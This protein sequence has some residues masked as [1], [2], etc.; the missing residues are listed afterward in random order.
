MKLGRV[1]LVGLLVLGMVAGVSAAL[2]DTGKGLSTSFQGDLDVLFRDSNGNLKYVDDSGNAVDTG[3][4]AFDV[5][6]VGD[7]DGDGDL[8]VLFRDPNNN[9]KYVDDS[10][11]LVDTG[12]QTN[13]V[14]GVADFDGDGDLDVLFQNKF[15]NLVYADDSGNRVDTNADTITV[16]GVGDFDGDGD[17]DVLFQDR[18]NNLKYVDDSGNAVDTGVDTSSVGG[19]G[20]FDG[21][22]DLDVLF[23]DTNSN[24]EY[25]DDSGNVVDTGQD[26]TDVGG[27]ADF[28]G[29]GDLDVLFRD[30]NSNLKYVDDSGNVVDTGQDTFN[31]GGIADFDDDTNAAP[32]FTFTSVNPEPPKI[33]ETADFSYS[34]SDPDG[35]ISQVNL[36][37]KDDGTQIFTGSKSSSTGTFS[38]PDTLTEG[39]ITAEFTATDNA[40]ATN[41]ETLTRTLTDTKPVV[42]ISSPAGTV[43][44]YDQ[45]INVNT[46]ID[47]DN[48]A[49]EQLSCVLDIDSNQID[50]RTVTEGDNYTLNTR[51]DLG[52][53]N[54]NV[55][56]TEQDDQQTDSG[57]TSFT[58]ENFKFQTLTGASTA[59][60]TTQQSFTA[61]FKA[62]DMVN[63]ISFDLVYDGEVR[64]QATVN[65]SGVVDSS[66]GFSHVLNLAQTDGVNRDYNVSA[67]VDYNNL[68][69]GTSTDNF[70]SSTNSQ[71]VNQ[72]FSYNSSVFEDGL[73]QL[74]ASTLDFE[75]QIKK[76]V[77]N[78]RADLSASSTLQQTGETR[79]LEQDGTNF[80]GLIDTDLINSTSTTTNLDTTVTVSFNGESRTF[81]NTDTVTLEKI[82]LSKSSSTGPKTLQFETRDEINNS[83]LDCLGRVQR[84][85]L[86]S[87]AFND[88]L[89]RRW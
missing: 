64:D 86:I 59:K 62:G 57:S 19:V 76:Q 77:T 65:V 1:L 33:G 83:L 73:T 41:T 23:R 85:S 61:G 35:N 38:P 28:D 60:E 31:V 25:V 44:D 14:G 75:A 70:D 22:G 2:P 66:Q 36:T 29:D 26:S 20:D 49:N 6:G 87:S 15:G 58:V 21:D 84:L 46:K 67:R 32:Q 81:S 42:N 24:L 54:V 11:N 79:T 51:A 55:T 13:N 16:G 53:H 27:V 7:F 43:F 50:Q 40:G 9:L 10:G 34:A 37:L 78:N 17:L 74:E 71:T 48:N 56:C 39:D 30:T 45:S 52:S 4:D 69:T 5:G 72:A 63:N 68:N 80:T 89:E 8:D 88:F 12:I 18:N 82:Q 3:V 47:G